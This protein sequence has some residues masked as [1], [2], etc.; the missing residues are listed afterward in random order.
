VTRRVLPI[1]VVLLIGFACWAVYAPGPATADPA[2]PYSHGVNVY[3][4]LADGYLITTEGGPHVTFGYGNECP[5]ALVTDFLVNDVVPA[6]RETL[7]DGFVADDY[8]P[9]APPTAKSFSDPVEALS[10]IETEIYY[11]PEFLYWDGFTPTAV[12]C[13]YGGTFSFDMNNAG[14]RYRFNFDRC[15]FT[16]NFKMTGS[17][18]YNIELDRF[19]LDVKTTGRWTCDVEYVRRG[20]RV[21]LS[22]KCNGK[23]IK[24]D[25]ADKDSNRH[26]VP[27]L[28]EPK[29]D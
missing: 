17:G 8:V 4:H 9:V 1:L 14:T 15:A 23:P 21:N 24:A 20:D 22:G 28:Y 6:D 29:K 7:C 27:T 3:Q 13:T 2:T 19:V 10:S 25:R 26:Q 16:A 5:D 12:G 18:V 11:L